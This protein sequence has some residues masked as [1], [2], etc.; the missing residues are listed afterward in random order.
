MLVQD[1]FRADL[2]EKFSRETLIIT[3][4]LDL[5]YSGELAACRCIDTLGSRLN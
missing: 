1:E 4:M 5:I 3:K 2:V